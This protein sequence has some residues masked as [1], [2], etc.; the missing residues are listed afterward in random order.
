M[1]TKW[2]ALFAGV[3]N[4]C[5]AA[6]VVGMAMPGY[7]RVLLPEAYGMAEVVPR[8]WTDAPARAE[9][10]VALVE[11]SRAEV[12]SFFAD[13]PPQPTVVLCTTR[14]CARAFGIGGNGLSVADMAVLVSPG[15]LTAGTL[16]HE[17]AHSRL[18]RNMG[19]RNIFRQPFPTWFDEGL[20]THVANHPRWPGPVGVDARRRV[21]EVTR[22]WQLRAAF[23]EI[24]VGLTYR[25]AAAEVA[26]IETLIGRQGLLD[27][28]ARADAGE[29]FQVVLNN[30]ML[31]AG[32]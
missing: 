9:E 16:T 22:H 26:A 27:L 25:A 8:V 15:G 10:L 4:C 23:D 6:I 14:V 3:T 7:H 30:L 20:A 32:N 5:A 31:E 2:A 17:M 19:L 12:A 11:A 13:A 24:G 29:R 18:H 1:L 21:R 28:V